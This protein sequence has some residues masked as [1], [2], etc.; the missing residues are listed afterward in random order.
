MPG[1]FGLL[2]IGRRA[3][4]SQ[5]LSMNVTSHNIANATTPGYTRQRADLIATMPLKNAKGLFI[6]TGVSVEGIER[7]RNRFLDNQ[8]RQSSGTLGSAS[9]R[10][11]VLSQIE[12]VLN[13]PSDHGLQSAMT[14]FFNS[15]QELSAHPE[16]AGPRNAVLSQATH[17]VSTF[18]RISN[19]LIAQRNNLIDDA[20]N[21]VIQINSLTRQIADLNAQIV[22]SRGAGNLPND[23]MDQRDQALDQLSQLANIS[24]SVDS[25]GVML[26]SIGGTLVAGNATSVPLQM[27]ATANSLTITTSGGYA[28]Q[29]GGGQLGGLMEM[30]N[31]TIPGQ[32]SQIDTLAN[33]IITRVNAVHAAGYGLGDPPRTGINFF[34]GT[35]ARSIAVNNT[36]SSNINNI[37]ASGDGAP[38]NNE[39]ALALFGIINEQLLD[40]G[41]STVSQFY[42]RFVSSI[43]SAVTSAT[44]AS[45]GA[46]LILSQLYAQRE[47]VSGVSL[48]EEMTNMIKF[49][50]SFEAA[51]R[52]VSTTDELM[53][54]I[55]NMV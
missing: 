26:V 47:S 52:L 31:T 13:E 16:D 19:G 53:K 55:L 18:N 32:Q 20:G 39:N 12:S 34:T 1:L 10:Q 44:A 17:L 35:D 46:E 6:G 15:F 41:T 48:D 11:G 28:L 50:R 21:K 43:G 42:N 22:S 40:G 37:A 27:S 54:T 2:E 51:A 4:A 9:L 5:Q 45:N 33:T 29:V 49:Q 7:L 24:A 38:G 23:L 3:L 36:I 25:Q 14:K 30:Y 8:Y